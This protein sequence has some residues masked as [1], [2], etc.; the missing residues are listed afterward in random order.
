MF[1]GQA[2]GRIAGPVF[3]AA[4]LALLGVAALSARHTFAFVGSASRTEGTVVA[5]NA[6]GSHPQIRFVTADGTAVSYPQ[7][8]LIFG[9]RPGDRVQVLFHPADPAGTATLDAVGSL[10]FT[11]LLLGGLGV[12]CLAAG[13]TAWL[14]A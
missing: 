10:W 6:G 13:A 11:A 12:L 7:G 1:A 2:S 5:L 9:Y 14:A 4:G 8:G 3:M